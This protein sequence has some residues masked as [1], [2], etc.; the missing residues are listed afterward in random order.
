M[1]EPGGPEAEFK[2]IETL[3]SDPK[4]RSMLGDISRFNAMQSVVAAQLLDTNDSMVI[5]APTGSG[6]TVLHELSIL[7][8]IKEQAQSMNSNSKI[9]PKILFIAPTKALCSQ[10]VNGTCYSDFVRRSFIMLI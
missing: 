1:Y 3:I 8:L 4:M 9:K 7:R 2:R 6:K 10:R 5:S